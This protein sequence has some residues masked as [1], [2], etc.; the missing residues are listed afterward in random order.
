M[1]ESTTKLPPW[2]EDAAKQIIALGQKRSQLGYVP[3]MGPDV[4]AMDPN[5]MA[6]IQGFDAMSSAFGMPAGGAA[7]MSYLPQAQTFAGGVK[8][9][10]GFPAFEEA[11]N[12]LKAK[13]PG[14]YNYLQSFS[15]NPQT[16]AP[17]GGGT[18]PPP[19]TPPAGGGTGTPGT[20]SGG[21]GSS[22]GG[23]TNGL[24]GGKGLPQNVGDII[25]GMSRGGFTNTGG[26]AG[27]I[28][29]LKGS[30]WL[31]AGGGDD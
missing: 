5:T 24:P 17:G 19:V 22:G 4:A 28:N 1:A 13:Y 14:I 7:S 25:S 18:T 21:G 23:D 10:S 11:Q 3:Y 8:G 26:L 9:Y 16:G 15:I 29:G 27:I 2:Y 31:G 20:G 12:A 6:G 30:G